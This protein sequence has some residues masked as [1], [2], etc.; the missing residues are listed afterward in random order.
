MS[1][2]LSLIL[3]IIEVL[4]VYALVLRTEQAMYM[5]CLLLATFLLLTLGTIVMTKN[6]GSCSCRK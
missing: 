2:I 6:N 1:A 4:R 5:V 3:V